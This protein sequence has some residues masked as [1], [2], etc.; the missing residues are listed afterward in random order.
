MDKTARRG[1][2][3]LGVKVSDNGF[4]WLDSLAEEEQV[5]SGT[6]TTRS[7]VV[8]AALY[9]ARKHEGEVFAVL[10]ARM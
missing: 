4:K 8:R 6:P 9:V 10:R 3:F 1:R 5:G 2:Q 7:D